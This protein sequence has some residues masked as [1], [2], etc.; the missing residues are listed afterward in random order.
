MRRN[1]FIYAV[2]IL[3]IGV[4][5]TLTE[6]GRADPDM[7]EVRQ[8]MV[9]DQIAH[10]RD[11]R[12]PVR[13]Q[14]VL[15]AMEKVPRHEFVP[16]EQRPAAY[17]DRPLPIGHGQT[18]SQPYIVAYMTELLQIDAEH[19]VLEI[20]TGSGYQ[21]AVLGELAREVYSIEIVRPLAA[22]AEKTLAELDYDNVQ[23]RAGD[24]YLG[25]PEH[26]PFDRIIVTAAPDHVP[27]PLIDQLRPG[28]RMVLPVG[29]VWRVQELTLVIK[30]EDGKVEQSEVMAV[31]FVPLT[32]D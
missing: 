27:Q 4:V 15:R 32:R 17:N 12:P 11:M 8:R 31:G 6:T 14:R 9:D 3:T 30:R 20:G 7:A 13:D 19:K 23:V 28:G 25:W 10:P 18:I 1:R 24:G 21:A 16:A 26:A 22:R 2:G 29:E 5:V